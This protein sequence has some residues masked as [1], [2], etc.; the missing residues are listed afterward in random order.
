[1]NGRP[2][3]AESLREFA[4]P[5]MWR[6][7]FTVVPGTV[8][9]NISY[10]APDDDPAR[11]AAAARDAQA[12]DFIEALPSGYETRL[13]DGEHGFSTGQVRLLGVARALA[14]KRP[15]LVRDEPTGRLDPA[16]GNALFER[17]G[18]VAGGYVIATH[19]LAELEHFD[20]V[21]VMADNTIAYETNPSAEKRRVPAAVTA[22]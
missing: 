15:F 16:S 5:Y 11:C 20:R 7:S 17:L 3:T 22:S 2:R 8:R 4:R 14:A 10:A 6:A 19:D 13:D 18:S 21:L 1:M 9:E 12:A